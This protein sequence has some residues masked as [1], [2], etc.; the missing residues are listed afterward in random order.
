MFEKVYVINLASRPDRL[1]AFRKRIPV[2][3]PF[4]Y[5][6]VFTGIE[7]QLVPPP[8]WWKSGGGAW[9][10]HRTHTRIQEDCLNNNINS[11]MVCEDDAVF[12]DGFS[13]KAVAFLNNLPDDWQ[14]VYLG[15][16]HI[17]TDQ[18]LPR[19]INDWVYQPYNINR[20]HCYILRGRRAI[21]LYFRH[22]TNYLDWQSPHHTD[23]RLGELHKTSPP[24]LYCPREWLVGQSEGRSD[25]CH[26]DLQLRMF[27]GAEDLI[28][29]RIDLSGIAILGTFGSGASCVAGV[30][31]SLDISLGSALPEVDQ[32]RVYCPF[33][34]K[35]LGHICRQSYT[36]PWLHGNGIYVDRTNQ[37]R[38]WAGIQ[39][40]SNRGKSN[41]FAGKHSIL[42]LM[43]QELLEA[44][45]DPYFVCVD[46][47]HDA[48][49]IDVQKANWGWH[50]YAIDHAIR[51]QAAARDHFLEEYSPRFLRMSLKRLLLCPEN[52][53][54]ELCNF[55]GYMP[56]EVQFQQAITFVK[57]N[58]NVQN[59]YVYL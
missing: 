4:P 17:Q 58:R 37:L 46:R 31:Y 45:Q 25:I 5:P 10:C 35:H 38:H 3:W 34:D 56:S 36:E 7:G 19:K 14:I 50:P 39:C 15:G 42:S 1:E 52:T 6:E 55:V 44:W 32:Q 26:E 27:A 21:E 48:C 2:D 40:E 53:I 16:Q 49:C 24:G 13:E 30:L 28:C 41:F 9:G 43:G 57:E 12:V 47:N 22:L 8:I 29:P 18:R 23:H 59:S 51:L 54:L 20:N 33:E 11:V